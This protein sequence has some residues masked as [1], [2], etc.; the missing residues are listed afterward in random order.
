VKFK[1]MCCHETAEPLTIRTATSADIPAIRAVLLA[2][3]REYGVLGDIGAADADL[4]DLQQNYFARGGWFEV[5]ADARGRIVGC[6]GLYPLS[7]CRAE[8]CKM[9]LE[10]SARGRGLGRRLLENLVTAARR[11][12]FRE[13]WLETN[14]TLHEAIALYRRY[15]FEPVEPGRL[16][17]RCDVAYLLRL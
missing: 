16:L 7:A 17:P 2:V 1:I 12:N 3:R 5:I 14:S 8:L 4:D 15:G 10:K 9:Y 11:G 13:V 6:A